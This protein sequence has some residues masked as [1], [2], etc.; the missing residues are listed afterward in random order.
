MT[1][2]ESLLVGAENGIDMGLEEN[3]SHR[4]ALKLADAA[5][6]CRYGVEGAEVD[7][8]LGSVRHF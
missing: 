1:D 5:C 4:V 3:A 2:A 8:F 7:P 6:R